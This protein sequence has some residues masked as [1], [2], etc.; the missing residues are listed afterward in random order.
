MMMLRL[1]VLVLSL[2]TPGLAFAPLQQTTTTT[3]LN[4]GMVLDSEMN[5]KY[6]LAKAQECAFSDDDNDVCS[7]TQAKEYLNDILEIQSGCVTGTLAGQSLCS[8]DHQDSVADIVAHL[9]QKVRNGTS[10]KKKT[11]TT[12]QQQPQ[13]LE[14]STR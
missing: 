11:G 7:L 9:R 12:N 5:A 10:S 4:A 6:I 14:S 1:F 3:K 2:F 13:G 8:L